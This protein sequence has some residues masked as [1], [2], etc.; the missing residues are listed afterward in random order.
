MS[1]SHFNT[2][3]HW[4]NLP[5]CEYI[6]LAMIKAG[7]LRHGGPE[8]KTIQLAQQGK[9]ETIMSNKQPVS[10]SDILSPHLPLSARVILIE[11]APGGGKSTLVLHIC[12]KWAQDAWWLARYRLVVLVYLR[13]QA[14]QNATTLADILPARNSDMSQRTVSQIQAVDGEGMLFIFDGW[15]EYPPGLMKDSVVSTII[16]QPH[17]YSV[18]K[19]TVI[20]TSRPVSTGNLLTIANSRLEI[21]GFTRHQIHEYIDKV[22]DCDSTRVQKLVQHLEENPVIEGYCY[23]PLHAA[24]L[25]HVFQT[26]KGVLPTTR[27]ELFCALTICCIV[28]EVETH[29]E[30]SISATDFLSLPHD[31]KEKLSNHCTLAYKGVMQNKVVFYQDDL[32]RANLPANLPSL[33]L[34]QA[35][36]SIAL[37]RK[38]ISYNFLHLSIQELLAAYHISQMDPSQQLNIFQLLFESS[39]LQPV[40]HYYSGFTKLS[41]PEIR[42]YISEFQARQTCCEDILPLLHCL[43]EAQKPSA[44]WLINPRF[45]NLKLVSTSLSP[46]DYLAVGY[47][48]CSFLATTSPTG[49]FCVHLYIER[50]EN[51]GL[52][53]LLRELAKCT[54][55]AGPMPPSLE[56]ALSTPRITIEG[57]RHVASYLEKSPPCTKLWLLQG[58]CGIYESKLLPSSSLD[59]VCHNFG[60]RKDN[61]RQPMYDKKEFFDD[62]LDSR[63]DLAFDRDEFY[64]LFCN[65]PLSMILKAYKICMSMTITIFKD[66]DGLLH[67]ARALQTNTNLTLLRL[68]DMGL[69]C[70][71]QNGLALTEML[72][73][74]QSL[75]SSISGNPCLSDSSARCIFQGLQVIQGSSKK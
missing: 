73:R 23:V 27:H 46:A 30:S 45:R 32:E 9:I 35:V 12:H 8:E 52:Q 65:Q 61:F 50:I 74:N 21:L 56:I 40:L 70:T 49:K 11:G 14:V 55:K 7:E 71:E 1:M 48:M 2:F 54:V 28:R 62:I 5:H 22:L 66:E 15:D 17:K 3:Q 47:C 6:K 29:D 4:A 51:H 53:L 64:H 18:H 42:D 59:D 58:R 75:K 44:C 43:F 25:V 67:I 16:R 10:L 36:E 37:T 41:N 63:Y 57:A 34:L 20:I 26:L 39:H 31:L 72:R 38:S 13:D 69:Q 60:I 24:I 19:S 68:M 33:G